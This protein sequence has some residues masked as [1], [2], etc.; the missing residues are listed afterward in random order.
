MDTFFQILRIF[1]FV[2][3]VIIALIASMGY[4]PKEKIW[5]ILVAISVVMGAVFIVVLCITNWN[6]YAI[7]KIVALVLL[8]GSLI[9]FEFD[10][11]PLPFVFSIVLIIPLVFL[12]SFVFETFQLGK[13]I[14]EVEEPKV[15]ISSQELLCA[16]DGA[17]TT[18][19]VAGG[20]FV[21]FSVIGSVEEE[22]VYKYYYLLP[23]GG[24]KLGQV[25]ADET[26]IYYIDEG[27]KPRLDKVTTTYY[28]LDYNESPPKECRH[29]STVTYKLYVPRGSISSVYEFDAA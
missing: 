5:T 4:I 14:K 26:T 19:N 28:S 15:V 2:A 11:N 8:L 13:N 17:I 29:K 25:N 16:N 24:A 10:W 22:S 12:G 1:L 6:Y 3:P 20:G 21:V 7:A 9:F 27:E 23:D 18:G